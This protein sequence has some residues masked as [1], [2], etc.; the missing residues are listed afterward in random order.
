ML[1]MSELTER[2]LREKMYYEQY[3]NMFD[4]NQTIDFSPIE[5]PMF[6]KERRPWN[7]YWRTY[8]LAVDTFLEKSGSG[9]LNLL[10]F[11]CGPGDN[12][13]RFN[14]IGYNVTGFD[15]SE[16]NVANCKELFAKNN[17]INTG[18]FLVSTAENIKLS[19]NS[20]DIVVGIDILHHVDIKKAMLE[21]KKLLKPGGTAVFREPVEVSFLD[22]LRNIK[23]IK[24]LVPNSASLEHH[25]TEDERKLNC[26]DFKDIQ[27][28]FPNIK[29]ERALI[30]SR[31][32]RFIR[33]EK[34]QGA[35][36]LER[37][38]FLMRIIPGYSRL[39]GG[40]V[41]ILKK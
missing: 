22:W 37:I 27:E 35:S 2:Q 23:L 33:N 20:F 14:R 9:E 6:E 34:S 7:S 12:S 26:R 16:T 25:I 41:I 8:E 38:D 13:L 17:A 30:L 19:E 10:D 3:A 1:F 29:I 24:A 32:D 21:I 31:L 11:G 39:G 28:V 4:T 40:A 18:K 5:G 15:I 36:I